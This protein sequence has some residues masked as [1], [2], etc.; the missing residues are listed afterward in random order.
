MRKKVSYC[1]KKGD[2]ERNRE[3]ERER[4]RREIKGKIERGRR[5]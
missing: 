5:Q 4:E 2:K 1:Q 3:R